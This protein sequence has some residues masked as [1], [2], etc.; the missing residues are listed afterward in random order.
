MYGYLYDR[1]GTG[2]K[3]LASIPKKDWCRVAFVVDEF[4]VNPIS[5]KISFYIFLC[6]L[7]VYLHKLSSN[8]GS[9]Y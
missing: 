8:L 7:V 9:A 4:N 2:A 1:I 6:I 3:T 5:F